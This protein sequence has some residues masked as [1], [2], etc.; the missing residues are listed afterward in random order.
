VPV[1]KPRVLAIVGPTAVGK[2]DFALEIAEVHGGEIISADSR[3]VYRYMDIGTAKP[4]PEM[5]QRVPHHLLDL[6]DPDQQ[7]SVALF[8]RDATTA[9]HE[10]WSRGKL[11]IVA[12]GTGLYVN[13]LL[14]GLELP[15]VPPDPS[16][17]AEL[18]RRIRAEGLEAVAAEL[19]RRDPDAAGVVDLRNPR[20]VIRALEVT[21]KS[22]QPFSAQRRRSPPD[23]DVLR[24][25]LT[26][27]RPLLYERINRRLEQQVAA[28][29][30]EE[31][32]G[33]L[34]RG[35]RPEDPGL[36]G[37]VYREFVRH[38][39]GELGLEEAIRLAQRET[40]RYA[41]RQLT[42][43]RAD[44]QVHWF[45][46]TPEGLQQAHA[47]IVQ[48]LASSPDPPLTEQPSGILTRTIQQR[49]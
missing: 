6:I 32:Q 22:G 38:V 2:S 7:Y 19:V 13:A 12:G 9:L 11:P 24:I 27:D 49:T 23:W 46:A 18:E 21:L 8:V 36:R 37:L 25:G 14:D 44:P 3:Q 34:A 16:L 45:E 26:L 42:W 17:R 43:F 15:A 30:V 31:V 28:G 29:L 1:P 41:K 33:L 39:L 20:R 40:R 10:I 4:S 5:R 35:Y 47:T 48:W